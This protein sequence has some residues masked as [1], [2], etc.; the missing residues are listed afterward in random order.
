M[1][2][3]RSGAADADHTLVTG[4]VIGWGHGWGWG[5]STWAQTSCTVD[6]SVN[7][8]LYYHPTTD[9]GVCGYD[10]VDWSAFGDF[11]F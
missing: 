2:K 9:Y 4:V 10:E 7:T 11:S 3:C 1:N 6:T 8:N 5:H